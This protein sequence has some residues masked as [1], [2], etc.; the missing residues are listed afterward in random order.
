MNQ[1]N[2]TRNRLELTRMI[3]E[4]NH[5]NRQRIRAREEILYGK[6]YCDY[7]LTAAEHNSPE[8]TGHMSS[9]GLRFLAAAVL[10]ALYFICKTQSATIAG[11]DSAQIEAAVNGED[12]LTQSLPVTKIVDFIGQFPYTLHD[13]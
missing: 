13:S 2:R 3:R 12:S 6:K 9:F 1:D 10:F 5:N 7:P 8:E 11:I 4:E